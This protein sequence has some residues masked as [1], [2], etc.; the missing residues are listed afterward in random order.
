MLIRNKFSQISV[1]F[2][3][4]CT[5]LITSNGVKKLIMAVIA[6]PR[7]F[8]IHINVIVIAMYVMNFLMDND[9]FSSFCESIFLIK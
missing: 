1:E 2:I 7:I 8:P 5:G 9:C 3:N 6:N 4:V